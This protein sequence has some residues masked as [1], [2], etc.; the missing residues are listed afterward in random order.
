[1][2]DSFQT[3]HYGINK[4]WVGCLER[5]TMSLGSADQAQL[6]IYKYHFLVHGILSLFIRHY[7]SPNGYWLWLD[8]RA[9][10]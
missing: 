3:S 9:W 2:E 6:D 10:E 4:D 7:S 5:Y 1:M 8:Y